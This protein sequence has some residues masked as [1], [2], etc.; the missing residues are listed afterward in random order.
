MRII[1]F[2]FHHVLGGVGFRLYRWGSAALESRLTPN[3]AASNR[4][5]YVEFKASFLPRNEYD[6]K[7]NTYIY[8]NENGL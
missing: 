7:E 6:V 4:K 1:S 3:H 5:K 2:N 8:D